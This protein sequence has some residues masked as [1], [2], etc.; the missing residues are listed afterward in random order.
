M[1]NCLHIC[2]HKNVCYQ[3]TDERERKHMT[4]LPFGSH[5]GPL[6]PPTPDSG[7]CWDT[8]ACTIHTHIHTQ[9]QGQVFLIVYLKQIKE[10]EDASLFQ[11]DVLYDWISDHCTPHAVCG[12]QQQSMVPETTR[13]G[14]S[15]GTLQIANEELH[16]IVATK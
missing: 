12:C 2:G 11:K 4:M 13:E 15:V 16:S 1:R 9:R 7:C 14:R 3:Y 5:T 6:I 10:T 8:P